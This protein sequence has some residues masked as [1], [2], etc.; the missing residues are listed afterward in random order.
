MRRSSSSSV[1]PAG[2][3]AGSIA[4]AG[5]PA[6]LAHG[7]PR[8]T[9]GRKRQQDSFGGASSQRCQVGSTLVFEGIINP[10]T[11]ATYRAGAPAGE[12]L[13]AR[14][15]NK[16]LKQLGLEASSYEFQVARGKLNLIVKV[17]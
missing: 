14:L 6:R 8:S 10:E 3:M 9:P 7:I 1:V 4:G 12:S 13:L 11:L 5:V 17:K 2:R 16:A 15:G